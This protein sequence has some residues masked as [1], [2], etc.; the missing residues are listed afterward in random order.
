MEEEVGQDDQRIANI[1]IITG[2][3]NANNDIQIQAL[4][5]SQS[6]VLASANI[7]WTSYQ[8]PTDQ[9]YVH[10]YCR[11]FST[12]GIPP[13]IS[14]WCWRKT[15]DPSSR[16]INDLLLLP[17]TA[18]WRLSE[19]PHIHLP[20]PW[21][22]RWVCEFGGGVR[23]GRRWSSFLIFR[24]TSLCSPKCNVPRRTHS[25]HT[26]GRSPYLSPIAFLQLTIPA[27]RSKP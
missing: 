9:A 4:E 20:L 6:H 27:R 13:H 25:S 21:P 17:Q 14:K 5:V 24:R 10:T 2:L 3:P 26:G 18:D 19:R 1:V 22:R 12:K 7:C 8:A 15:F 23:M 16:K 11:T